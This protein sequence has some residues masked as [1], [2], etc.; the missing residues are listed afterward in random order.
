MFILGTS[1]DSTKSSYGLL[2]VCLFV[3]D[4]FHSLSLVPLDLFAGLPDPPLH[5]SPESPSQGV[6]LYVLHHCTYNLLQAN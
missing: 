4:V 6:C 1:S 3:S 2:G 5:S